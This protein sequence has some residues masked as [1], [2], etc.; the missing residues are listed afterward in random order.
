[1]TYSRET[2]PSVVSLYEGRE[3]CGLNDTRYFVNTQLFDS[4][5]CGMFMGGVGGVQ[6]QLKDIVSLS[7]L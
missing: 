1:M 2:L 7:R 3:R 4:I 5:L 6:S